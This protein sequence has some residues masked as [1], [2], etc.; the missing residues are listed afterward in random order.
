VTQ[1]VKTRAWI[2][3]ASG[4]VV[5]VVGVLVALGLENWVGHLSDRT[6]EIRYLSSLSED[7][8]LDSALFADRLLPRVARADSAIKKIAPVARGEAPVPADTI[9][10]LRL[11]IASTA[12]FS[13]LGTRSTFDELLAT[14]SL[15]L[16][17]SPDIRSALV[18]YYGDKILAV[19]RT[20]TRLSGFAG[21]VRGHLPE[22]ASGGLVDSEEVM[23]AE[24]A[25]RSYG[26]RQAVEAVRTP[27]FVQAMNRHISL[28]GLLRPML[29]ALADEVEHLIPQVDAE[30]VR[31][32]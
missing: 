25:L 24:E 30:L 26:V 7:L 3:A 12:S 6:S 16:V 20:S 31:L 17:E 8:R 10:F 27:E 9:A 19:N 23:E 5:I 11:V 13:Q 15:Q 28:L 21:L 14:G 18:R 32:H 22:A 29:L 1:G 4:F 2:R